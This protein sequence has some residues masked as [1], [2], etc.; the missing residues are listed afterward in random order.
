MEE[1]ENLII[2]N[3][4][5]LNGNLD[6]EKLNLYWCIGNELNKLDCNLINSLSKKLVSK[7]GDEYNI[8]NLNNMYQFYMCYPLWN[9]E[10]TKLSFD[11]YL[12]LIKIKDKDKREFYYK[13]TINNKWDLITLE[14][15]I[16]TLY[17]ESTLKINNYIK[18][19]EGEYMVLNN[20]LDISFNSDDFILF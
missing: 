20:K 9:D 11:Y 4:N 1:I 13:E 19:Q 14:L 15:K 5:D 12:E 3:L 18:E 7:Y 16:E 8:N 6:S 17:Y 2:Y 10:L